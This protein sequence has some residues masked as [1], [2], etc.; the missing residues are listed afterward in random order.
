MH[1]PAEFLSGFRKTDKLS[2]VISLVFYYGS[3]AWDGSQDVY[4]LIDLAGTGMKEA[5]VE[6]LK[7]YIPNY[8][9]NL[10]Q[11]VDLAENNS[12]KTDLQWMMGMLKYKDNKTELIQYMKDHAVF[13]G[14]ISEDEFGAVKVLL[15]SKHIPKVQSQTEGNGGIDMCRA[16]DEWY[17]DGV[18]EGM[19]RGIAQG[20]KRGI[21]R[22]EERFRR[23]CLR[24]SE[25]G[26]KEA[27]EKVFRDK[28]YC[29][30]LYEKYSL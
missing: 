3:K 16:L 23:L 21:E 24:L 9:M 4:G 7:K 5:D 28:E 30:K 27:L 17:Q 26:D 6:L 20:E 25:T 19:E 14:N 8:R 22:G 12:F 15:G 10:I 2:P 29:R 11:A 1:G 13:F 18:N